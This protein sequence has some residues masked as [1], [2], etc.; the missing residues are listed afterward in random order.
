MTLQGPTVVASIDAGAR[1]AVHLTPGGA[2]ALGL[3]P[4]A[5]LWVVIKTYSCRVLTE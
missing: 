5:E 2:A 3:Q 4:G 1:L